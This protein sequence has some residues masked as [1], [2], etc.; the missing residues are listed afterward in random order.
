[1]P[2]GI[3]CT[4]KINTNLVFKKKSRIKIFVESMFSI[5]TGTIDERWKS[6]AN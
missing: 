1:M 5:I 4:I 3:D 2:Y 6:F